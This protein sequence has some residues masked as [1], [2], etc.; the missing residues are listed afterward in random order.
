MKSHAIAE[1]VILPA[2]Q[3]MVRIMFREDAVSE[4]NKILLS[5]KTI[6]RR[7]QDMSGDI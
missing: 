5:D 1:S 4:V 2:C 6:S 7:I 3:E